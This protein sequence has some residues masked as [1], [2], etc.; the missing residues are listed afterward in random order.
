MLGV[1]LKL[2]SPS[3]FNVLPIRSICFIVYRSEWVVRCSARY[4]KLLVGYRGRCKPHKIF[5]GNAIFLATMFLSHLYVGQSIQE[6]TKQ[7]LRKTALKKIYLV[8]SW[9]LCPISYSTHRCHEYPLKTFFI[10]TYFFCKSTAIF[11]FFV[12]LKYV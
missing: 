1:C 6:W 8:H 11:K 7:N 2:V 5:K 12:N 9:I 3:G 4:I 10:Y